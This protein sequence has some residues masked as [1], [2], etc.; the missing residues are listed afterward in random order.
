[1]GGGEKQQ[2]ERKP[3]SRSEEL[4][5]EMAKEEKKPGGGERPEYGVLFGKY[6]MA[7]SNEYKAKRQ[8]A[9]AGAGAGSETLGGLDTKITKLETEFGEKLSK[10]DAKA[11]QVK[12]G[13]AEALTAQLAPKPKRKLHTH[14]SDTYTSSM[15]T[16][17]LKKYTAKRSKPLPAAELAELQEKM[18]R[19]NGL[20]VE[21]ALKLAKS[22]PNL[23]FLRPRWKCSCCGKPHVGLKGLE[24]Q[25]K[26]EDTQDVR[27]K[28][29]YKLNVE[30][31]K[32]EYGDGKLKCARYISGVLGL[33]KSPRNNAG[34]GS[35][36]G[37]LAPA[38]IR[39]N[40][41]ASGG[42]SAG[43]VFG[44]GNFEL[45]DVLIFTASKFREGQGKYYGHK[46]A[47]GR[48]EGRVRF[49]HAAIVRGVV[50]VDGAKYLAVQE[51][52]S[53]IELNFLPINS[54]KAKTKAFAK[55]LSTK[56]GIAELKENPRLAKILKY[57]AGFKELIRV[58]T[59]N[60][61][62]D[63][64]KNPKGR[65][66]FAIRTKNIQAPQRVAENSD[67]NQT[68]QQQPI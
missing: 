46:S 25:A 67:E 29:R 56:K 9:E 41:K 64:M 5:L 50:V 11:T 23:D 47:K 38:L 7:R 42:A 45:G 58:R 54:T 1:M 18:K 33:E 8:A 63:V 22:H 51:E 16:A 48:K 27:G 36:T 2:P 28:I 3:R 60:L 39:A 31:D 59:G 61:F 65:I 24:R 57:R 44:I 43:L 68:T 35:V 62:S 10:L 30:S 19:G 40:L 20:S 12:E 14:E 37:G 34:L 21:E 53:G 15:S 17:M 26:R 66:S 13:T 4:A 55:K 6:L 52:R 32:E 49:N